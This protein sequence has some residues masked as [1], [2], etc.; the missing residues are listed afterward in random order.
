MEGV[1]LIDSTKSSETYSVLT[2]DEDRSKCLPS[3]QHAVRIINHLAMARLK[4]KLPQEIKY[5]YPT[6]NGMF[7]CEL[8]LRMEKEE[9]LL[10]LFEQYTEFG[11]NRGYRVA[12]YYSFHMTG[13]KELGHWLMRRTEDIRCGHFKPLKD[14]R[15]ITYNNRGKQ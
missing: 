8:T 7:L 13:F 1:R 4:G 11:K 2:C 10:L 15:F 14:E 6:H 5:V 12:E 3:D 9:A